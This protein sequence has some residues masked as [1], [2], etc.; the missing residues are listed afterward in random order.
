MLTA[1]SRGVPDRLPVTVH[2]WQDY[3]LNTYMGG[4]DQVEAF[5]RTGLDAAVSPRDIKF[6]IPTPDWRSK[7]EPA[8]ETGGMSLTRRTVEF[9]GGSLTMLSGKNEYT[10]FVVEHL[11]KGERD[12]ENFLRFAPRFRLDR[13]RLTEWYDRTGDSG[14][15]RGSVTTFHQPGPWQSFCELVGTEQAI[16]WTVDNPALVHHFL[17]GLA[18]R[19]VEFVQREWSGAKFDLVEHGGGA[20]STSVISPAMFTEFCVPYDRMV[21][22]A[23][24][25]AGHKVVYHTCGWMRALADRIASNGCDASETLSPQGVGGDIASSADRRRIKEVL[26]GR[27]AL[28]GGIDQGKLEKP[29]LGAEIARDV[30]ACFQDFGPGGG[31]ICSASDHFFHALPENLRAMASAASRCRY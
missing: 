13:V 5:R 14:I 3:H 10:T 19:S 30:E 4:V 6:V 17:D 16:Y 26:G 24:H 22:A 7:D 12:A 23:L 28:V 8:G 29:G 1:L 20:A 15:V 25:E 18:Q 11:I 9:P 2:Q 31:Y 27:V 21:I